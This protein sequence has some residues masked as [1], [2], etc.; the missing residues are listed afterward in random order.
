MRSL[1][2]ILDLTTEE[3][4]ALLE[5]ADDIIHLCQMLDKRHRP[6]GTKNTRPSSRDAA[7]VLCC[8]SDSPKAQIKPWRSPPAWRK[9]QDHSQPGQPASCG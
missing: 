8:I 4:D 1:I 2:D 3:I 7:G 5:T 9:R 6:L